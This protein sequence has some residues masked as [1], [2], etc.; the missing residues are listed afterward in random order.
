M[1]LDLSEFCVGDHPRASLPGTM[2]RSKRN[3]KSKQY[4]LVEEYDVQ[5]DEGALDELIRSL[6]LAS[7]PDHA[8]LKTSSAASFELGNPRITEA[9]FVVRNSSTGALYGFAATYRLGS[10]GIVGAIFVDPHKRSLSIGRSLHRRA[11]RSLVQDRNVKKMQ[12]GTV[13]PGVFLGI[14]V[15][16]GSAVKDWFANSGWDVQFPRRLTN[17]V[18]NDLEAWAAPEGLLQSIQ[19]ANISFDLIHGIE[20]AETV[21]SHVGS[22]SNP[23]VI[24]LYREALSRQCGVVRAKDAIDQLLGT[25]VICR[26]GNPPVVPPSPQGLLV[27][28]GLALMGVRQIKSQKKASVAVLTWILDDMYDSLKAMGFETLQAFEEITNSPENVSFPRRVSFFADTNI[29][30][31]LHLVCAFELSRH[32]AM[33]EQ[34]GGRTDD[35]LFFDD[36]FEP[37]N[38]ETQP[39]AEIPAAPQQEP[40]PPRLLRRSL[41]LRPLPSPQGEEGARSAKACPPASPKS[42][43]QSRH[44]TASPAASNRSSPRPP[45][46]HQRGPP[47]S[48]NRV[49]RPAAREEGQG[50][51]LDPKR[52]NP[53]RRC[54][55]RGAYG[56]GDPSLDASAATPASAE[57]PPTAPRASTP[58]STPGAQ[59]DSG[60]RLLSGANPRTK[61]TEDELAAK[62]EKMRILSAEKARKFEQAEQDQKDHDA[63]YA[64]GME[65]AR[66]RRVVE[67]ERRKRADEDRKKMEDERAKNRERKLK[68]LGNAKD[69]SWDDGKDQMDFHQDTR[70]NFRS[71]NGGVRGA[72]AG[73]LAGS[74]FANEDG[75]D[76]RQPQPVDARGRGRGRGRGAGR[77]GRG[78]RGGH[79][80]GD[81]DP[82][83]S[84]EQPADQ[85]QPRPAKDD[86]PA[87]PSSGAKP[88]ASKVEPAPKL[89]VAYKNAAL[90]GAGTVASAAPPKKEPAADKGP[91]E[92]PVTKVEWPAKPAPENDI[93]PLSSPVGRWDDEMEAFDERMAKQS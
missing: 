41:P 11:M 46:Q 16:E 13:F 38:A 36:D 39:T 64:R 2:R 91:A 18:I 22:Q 5:R 65:E 61:L 1:V 56:G 24:E 4:W 37:V 45:R 40:P 27:L 59:P 30:G 19:R 79:A 93:L 58:S 28:Q 49:P 12:L 47:P 10:V 80:G 89:E 44:N 72:K 51:L 85:D 55:C 71:A 25:V 53:G 60:T 9:H 70:R 86:F 67:A 84:Q 81:N 66:K 76:Q 15:D 54:S 77:G 90:K 68:A 33:E 21:L 78:G 14:P 73:G 87:L 17:L 26:E 82:V 92:K 48:R 62:M 31:G 75:D 43:A 74:R 34:F 35:A 8:Y 20:N 42:L 7:A 32:P 6:A 57:A 52:S 83:G 88:A 23:E 69:G 63:A 29:M 3:I 50:R